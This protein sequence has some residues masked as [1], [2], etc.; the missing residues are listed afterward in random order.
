MPI[1]AYAKNSESLRITVRSNAKHIPNAG[2]QASNRPADAL[3]KK[4][5][6]STIAFTRPDVYPGSLKFPRAAQD[7]I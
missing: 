1:D 2:S 5:L 3:F 7:S 6:L 4:E